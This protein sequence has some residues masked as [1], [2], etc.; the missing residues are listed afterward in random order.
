MVFSQWLLF[1]SHTW[2]GE[3]IFLRIL[4]TLLC[5]SLVGFLKENPVRLCNLLHVFGVKSKR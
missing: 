4:P 1:P 2:H 3:G 5:E